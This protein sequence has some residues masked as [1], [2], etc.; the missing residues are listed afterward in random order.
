[1]K[2][3]LRIY[4]IVL[5]SPAGLWAQVSYERI[6]RA[7]SEPGN[8]FTYSSS[9]DAHRFSGLK[10]ITPQN[11]TGLKPLWVYQTGKRRPGASCT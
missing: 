2:P 5:L 4:L 3:F 10:Q 6:V 1:M 9:Y 11:V 7:G 8:W